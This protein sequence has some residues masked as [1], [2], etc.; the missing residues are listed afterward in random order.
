MRKDRDYALILN[1][2]SFLMVKSDFLQFSAKDFILDESFQHWINNPNQMPSSEWQEW[3]AIHPERASAIEKAKS[4]IS[5][6][7]EALDE[8]V[9]LEEA[10]ESWMEI[11]GRL[12]LL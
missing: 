11:Q 8:V 3:L 2:R 1:R 9:A 6:V 5:A 10:E 4:F 12:V 7:S